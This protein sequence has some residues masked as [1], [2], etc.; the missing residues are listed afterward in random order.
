[1]SEDDWD[2]LLD[3][4]LK[5]AYLCSKAAV[6]MMIRARKGTIINEGQSYGYGITNNWSGTS[7]TASAH[8]HRVKYRSANS[9]RC[10]YG[11]Y[12]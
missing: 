5:S 10:P 12:Q 4:N 9:R 8:N 11:S 6:R 7:G 2:S 1:M 3:T